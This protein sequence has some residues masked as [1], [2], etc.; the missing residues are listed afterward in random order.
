MGLNIDKCPVQNVED[1]KCD[2]KEDSRSLVNPCG[3]LLRSHCE[4][5]TRLD[6]SLERGV[7][8]GEVYIGTWE[9]VLTNRVY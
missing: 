6:F 1:K 5:T 9:W 7:W 2:G 4:E 3:Y 8:N